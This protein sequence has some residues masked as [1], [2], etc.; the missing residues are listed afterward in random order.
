LRELTSVLGLFRS[1]PT[2]RGG[3][4]DGLTPQLMQLLIALRQ[5]A[6][7]RKDFATSDRIRNGLAEINVTLED[8]K[9]GTVW[10]VGS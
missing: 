8:R 6:R 2:N 3:G 7:G 9:D 1:T 10:R 5:E 4:G